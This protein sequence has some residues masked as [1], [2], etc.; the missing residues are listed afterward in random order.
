MEP[1]K[2]AQLWVCKLLWIRED[3]VLSSLAHC[4]NVRK[5]RVRKFKRN[6]GHDFWYLVRCCL[7][8]SCTKTLAGIT[9]HTWIYQILHAKTAKHRADRCRSNILDW[10]FQVSAES[11]VITKQSFMAFLSPIQTRVSQDRLL[12]NTFH[13]IIHQSSYHRL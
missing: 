9:H 7:Q 10:L 1:K 2:I 5:Q 8:E 12:P 11:L 4:H 13:F 3:P 6:V